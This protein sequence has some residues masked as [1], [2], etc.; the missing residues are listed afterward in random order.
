M[1]QKGFTLVEV[2]VV[3]AV[4][5]ILTMGIMTSI[6]QVTTFTSRS[7]SQ[8]R[9]LTNLHLAA[10]HI[11]KDLQM[12]QYPGM[13]VGNSVVLS[14]QNPNSVTLTWFDYTT[15]FQPPEE[16][17]DHFSTYTLSDNGMLERFYDSDNASIVGRHITY[18]RFTRQD[19]KVVNVVITAVGP[20]IHQ[21]RKTI[22][23][24]VHMRFEGSPQ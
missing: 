6:F 15:E 23:F 1:R 11:K 8:G 12:A 22:E 20:G 24:S 13:D 5:G 19:E 16:Q 18:L 2:L 17:R 10:L 14:P 21:W 7:N 3:L 9:A 4:G